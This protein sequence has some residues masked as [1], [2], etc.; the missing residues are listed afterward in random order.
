VAFTSVEAG[1]STPSVDVLDVLTRYAAGY[2]PMTDEDDP[3]AAD[4][5]AFYWDRSPLRAI[6]PLNAQT[7][8]RARRM[9]RRAAGHFT[10]RYSTAVEKVIRHLRHV[11]DHSWVQ[12][13]VIDIYRALYAA[14]VLQTVEAWESRAQDA[15]P[16]SRPRRVAAGEPRLV[17]A[18]LGLVLPGVFVAETMYGLVPEASKVCLCQLVQDCHA[19]GFEFI[20]V[21][22]PHDTDDFGAP[23]LPK[24]ATAHPCTRLGEQHVPLDAFLESLA[25]AWSRHFPGT[26][27]DW[28]DLAAQHKSQKEK[29]P[30][31]PATNLSD[32]RRFLRLTRAAHATGG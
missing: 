2:F 26:I 22:T 4:Q 18:L 8:A 31:P 28:L 3:D 29:T 6:L 10:I 17:G 23:L 9:A 12:G 32:A 14:G 30:P 19:A 11:R 13:Q 20:D 7:A 21:Q 1:M 15:A 24:S 5:P 16:P 27:T 25:A